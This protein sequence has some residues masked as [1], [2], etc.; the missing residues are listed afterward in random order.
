MNEFE[1]KDV[2]GG[3]GIKVDILDENNFL[4]IKETLTRIG[5]AAHKDK[6][7]FQS[8]HILHKQGKYAIVHFKEM[9]ILDGKNTTIDEND[10]GR[11][12]KIA[13]LLDEWGLL[14]IKDPTEI[15]LVAAMKQIRIVPFRDK[16][17]WELVQKYNIGRGA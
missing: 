10:I 16:G 12:N 2:F 8:A 1:K 13:Q 6:K 11:R 3:L 5:Y 15:T 17:Q 14:K 4:K 9:F 7:L